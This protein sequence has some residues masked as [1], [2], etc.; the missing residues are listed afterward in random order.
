M[1]FMDGVKIW[2]S[3]QV[4]DLLNIGIQKL[5]PWY[6]C[7]ISSSGYVDKYLKYV[8][9]YILYF[10]HSLLAAHGRLLS[11]SPHVSNKKLMYSKNAPLYTDSEGNFDITMALFRFLHQSDDQYNCCTHRGS[12]K[13]LLS[14][15]IGC[16]WQ[17]RD[18]GKPTDLMLWACP[19]WNY[20]VSSVLSKTT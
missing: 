14:L 17:Y 7:L 18:W 5:I 20:S 4:A 11:D 13:H 6:K 1:E 10:C 12:C 19:T 8:F 15:V 16:L 3:S 9:F 2:L